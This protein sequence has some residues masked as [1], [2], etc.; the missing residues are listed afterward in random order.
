MMVPTL[1]LELQRLY[2][3][4]FFSVRGLSFWATNSFALRLTLCTLPRCYEVPNMVKP[5][6]HQLYEAGAFA[7]I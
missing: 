7:S 4:T 6:S 3:T 1:K 2:G 5:F